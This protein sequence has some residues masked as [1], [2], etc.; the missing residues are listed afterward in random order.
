MVL[1]VLAGIY[2]GFV[3]WK[4]SP[5]SPAAGQ[6]ELENQQERTAKAIAEQIAVQQKIQRTSQQSLNDVQKTLKAVEEINRINRQNQQLQI[7]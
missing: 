2:F 5:L 3:R 7:I 6:A 4:A 1:A